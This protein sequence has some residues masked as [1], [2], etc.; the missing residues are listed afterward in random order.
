M[1]PFSIIYKQ[2]GNCDWCSES[3]SYQRSKCFN[4]LWWICTQHHCLPSAKLRSLRG[5][6]TL[7]FLPVEPLQW[8]K[9]SS[10]KSLKHFMGSYA[11]WKHIIMYLQVAEQYQL[12]LLLLRFHTCTHT[13]LSV[14]SL[15]LSAGCF[16]RMWIQCEYVVSWRQFI[17][18]MTG[19]N[20][21]FLPYLIVC[22]DC[23]R[24]HAAQH[25]SSRLIT[26]KLI[27]S[28]NK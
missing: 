18:H 15:F 22:N 19:E 26:L 7:L 16:T 9:T 1:W 28:E 17:L 8:R 6:F 2:L 10:K 24:T 3:V 23:K 27:T 11:S 21:F 4:L 25:L 5:H 14:R 20:L 13:H 12:R